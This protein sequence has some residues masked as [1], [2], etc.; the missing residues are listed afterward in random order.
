MSF[1]R[2]L[3]AAAAAL[4]W[5]TPLAAQTQRSSEPS[6]SVVAISSYAAPQQ[7][8]EM[9]VEVVNPGT[10]P[11]SDVAIRLTIHNRV[12]TRSELGF[13]LDGSPRQSVLA[14]TTEQLDGS[15]APGERRAVKVT[16]DLATLANTFRSGTNGVY[17][18]SIQLTVSGEP[19]QEA[20]TALPFFS[21]PPEKRLNLV[22]ALLVHRPAEFDPRG[23]YPA[24]TIDRDVRKAG[25]LDAM[26]D[27]IGRHTNLPLT[28][29]TTGVTL[30]QIGDLADGRGFVRRLPDGTPETV[31]STDPPSADARDL[32]GRLRAA[33]SPTSFQIASATY[34]RADIGGLI[35][36][37][38][39][40]DLQRQLDADAVSVLAHTGR[41]PIASVF[42]P[43]DGV[44]DARSA[45]TLVSKG[46]TTAVLSPEALPERKTRFGYDRPVTVSGGGGVTLRALVAD[47]AI[48]D[49]LASNDAPAAPVLA[50]QAALAE[51]A[52][53]FF[54]LP[55][56]AE[57]RLLVVSTPTTPDALVVR[58]FMK[59]IA[60]APWLRV[61]TAGDA[62]TALP[63]T[64]E[65]IP[66][67][68]IRQPDRPPLAVA[69]AARQ[70]LQKLGKV[71]G[72]EG[73]PLQSFER[74]VLAAESADWIAAPARGTLLASVARG[75]AEVTL[76]RVRVPGR[77]V[78]LTSRIAQIPVTIQNDTGQAIRIRVRL[79]STKII[80][81]QGD[82]RAIEV[83][84][85][86]E[87]V[88]FRAETRVTG[89]F[90]LSVVLETPDG[91][92][93]VGE[94]TIIVRSTA[95]SAVT[96]L[97]VGGGV[98]VL[99]LS[100]ARR[101]AKSRRRAAAG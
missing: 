78:T 19:A 24:G 9:T 14:V 51:T 15:L 53:S 2:L 94:G 93:R 39:L 40:D 100:W 79:D 85:G 64:D 44:L 6:F 28:L 59:A 72:E 55:A 12:F 77:Q 10:L 91:A 99:F 18:I 52:S 69:R 22:W 54:E 87:T 47:A 80:F 62:A 58:A 74:Y 20:F 70:E 1:F 7:P 63:P 81:P 90:P 3:A 49:R 61:R 32:L 34:A 29:A 57:E 76:S 27:M 68:A 4:L 48:R 43:A 38:M 31:R 33:W 96:L 84:P 37:G 97:A 101:V 73:Q 26:V 23:W 30:D 21:S 35:H 16:R 75:G 36:N 41:A 11:A 46:V 67:H 88:T 89:S 66:L 95:V 86:F 92:S 83:G 65:A 42:L 98:L 8:L 13:A 17:P 25:A 50:V 82:A 60:K 56:I 71:L 5:V 45:L